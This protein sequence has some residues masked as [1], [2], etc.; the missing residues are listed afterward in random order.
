MQYKAIV[1]LTIEGQPMELSE[2]VGDGKPDE[3]KLIVV[4]AGAVEFEIT[5]PDGLEALFVRADGDLQPAIS[6]VW[7]RLSGTEQPDVPPVSNP[8]DDEKTVYV[9]TVRR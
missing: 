2:R 4:P 3:P 6:L 1:G 5:I 9:Q 7:S 8:T